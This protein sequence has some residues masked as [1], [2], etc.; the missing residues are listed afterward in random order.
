MHDII[1]FSTYI[2]TTGENMQHSEDT[3]ELISALIKAESE[4]TEIKK[5]C[6]AKA[7]SFNFQYAD[8]T[9]VYN[10][11][12]PALRKYGLKCVAMFDGNTLITTLFH[13]SGQWIKS[14]MPLAPAS[15][16]PTDF[17]AII[18]YM[19]RYSYVTLLG[20][21]A[22]ED[23]E[24]DDLNAAAGYANT[25]TRENRTVATEEPLARREQVDYIIKM[26]VSIN[27]TERDVANHLNVESL[28]EMKQSD[29]AKAMAY[30]KS[31]T[32]K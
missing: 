25:T 10:A 26:A 11:T 27:V 7:G 2:A 16:K 23:V 31:R 28:Y 13:I 6:T 15:G 5:T 8:L 19:R 14:V 30:I 21:S 12:K 4:Y 18:T 32:K 3:K 1:H 22:D 9:E 29:F 24:C 20:I 17:G